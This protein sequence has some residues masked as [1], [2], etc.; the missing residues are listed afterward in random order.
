VRVL[1]ITVGTAAVLSLALAVTLALA[2]E[3]FGLSSSPAL[4][5]RVRA[6]GRGG[7]GVAVLWALIAVPVGGLLQTPVALLRGARIGAGWA[8]IGVYWL[9]VALLAVPVWLAQGLFPPTDGPGKSG[10][11]YGA[12]VLMAFATPVFAVCWGSVFRK[13]PDS[14]GTPLAEQIRTH[15]MAVAVLSFAFDGVFVG[16]MTG[17]SFR[18]PD[19]GS[20]A[21]LLPGGIFW[22]LFA[23]VALG[24]FLT[25]ALHPAPERLRMTTEAADMARTAASVLLC[26]LAVAQLGWFLPK[27]T[28]TLLGIP[29]PFVLMTQTGRHERLDGWL[30]FKQLEVPK[31]AFD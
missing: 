23:G 12:A 28:V 17:A 8:L 25:A 3:R 11:M 31:G 14:A 13:A 2:P 1:R 10:G 9:Y 30:R 20:F 6:E 19:A 18:F 7:E 29:V 22:G 26:C 4:Y 15:L 5:E 27:W 21:M 24:T 16:M